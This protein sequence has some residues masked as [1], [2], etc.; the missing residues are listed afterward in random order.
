MA[1]INVKATVTAPPEINIPLVR[2]DQAH[3]ANVFRVF[4]EIFL[5]LFS[6]LLGYALGLEEKATTIHWLFVIVMGLSALAFLITSSV[7][8]RKA[9]EI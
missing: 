7:V 2:A 9:R 5:S 3:T 1:R 4:F 6:T 8:S